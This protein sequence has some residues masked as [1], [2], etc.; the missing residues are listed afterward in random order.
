[1][2]RGSFLAL[3]LAILPRVSLG[4]HGG[5]ETVGAGQDGCGLCHGS[6]AVAPTMNN[7][8][9]GDVEVWIGGTTTKL[10]AV[11]QSCL[12]CH[13][14]ADL[15]ARQPEMTFQATSEAEGARYLGFDFGG[16]HVLG[17]GT[18]ELGG[19][20]WR[21]E[22][23]RRPGAL[24][25][26][27]EALTCTTC[28]DPHDRVSSRPQPHQEASLCGDCHDVMAYQATHPSLACSDCHALHRGTREALLR[29]GFADDTCRSC[30]DPSGDRSL[31]VTRNVL[32]PQAHAAEPEAA[33]GSCVECHQVHRPG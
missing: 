28:H 6:H 7:L 33:F 19:T 13:L 16:Q 27:F 4:Q 20:D 17:N 14:S 12:R 23:R 25:P 15:R 2:A 29:G 3:L 5:A 8:K 10:D 21:I 18:A 9:T 30:H 1:M 26:H 24:V 22:P 31:E 32:A 11:A